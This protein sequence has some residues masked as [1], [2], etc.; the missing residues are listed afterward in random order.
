MRIVY[1]EVHNFREIERLCWAP[2]PLV[3]CLIGPGDSTKTTVLDAIELALNSRSYLFADDSDFYNMDY[4]KPIRIIVTVG[5]LPPEFTA[6]DRYGLHLRAWNQETEKIEDEPRVG[7]E[8]VLSLSAMVDKSHEVRWSLHNDRIAA[9]MEADP[10]S[11][12]YKDAIIFATT[13]LGPYAERHLGWSRASVLNRLG[14]PPETLREQ[15]ADAGRAARAAFTAGKPAVFGAIAARAEELS[16]Q[17]GVPVRDKYAAELDVHGVNLTAGGLSL[18]DGKLPLRR[19]GTGSSRLIVSALQDEAGGAHVALIDELEHGLEPYRI[20]RL[21][22]HL[23]SPRTDEAK[24]QQPQIFL[25]THSPVVIRELKAGDIWAVRSVAGLT[26]VRSVSLAAKTLTDAQRHLRHEPD[27]FLA[28]KV[29]VCEGRT[30]LGLVRGLDQYWTEKE[31]LDSFAVRGSVAVD[32][33]GS[34]APALADHLCE[35]GYRVFLLL[36]TDEKV[37][38]EILKK[39]KERGVVVSEWPDDCSTEQRVFLDVPWPVLLKLVALAAD[40][41][42]ADSVRAHLNRACDADGLPQ[43][44]KLDFPPTLDTVAFRRA[45]GKAAKTSEKKAWFKDINRG[46]LLAE[47][48]GPALKQTSGRPLGMGLTALREWIDG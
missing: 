4:N 7:L 8:E 45:L 36:D 48:L 12:R 34:S 38:S 5:G 21:L 30:E 29:V 11:L 25:T 13:R 32:G 9:D 47:I 40:C 35:L 23:A 10:P 16:K 37:D 42:T 28:R 26:E 27:A 46:E 2:R 22:R 31:K 17:F 6:D 18:H 44:E 41:V 24:S 3:N 43:Q 1:V 39:L 33:H 14:G 15:L 20:A 19:L